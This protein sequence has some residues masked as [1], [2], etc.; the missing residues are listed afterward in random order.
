MKN[1]L[2][3]LKA[4][5]NGLTNKELEKMELWI[6]NDKNIDVIAVDEN[7]ISLITDEEKLKIDG[8]R[9]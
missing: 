5:L 6:D 9:W 1:A 8:F 3:K 7:A 4:I 2:I